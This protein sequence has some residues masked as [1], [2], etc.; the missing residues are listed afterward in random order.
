PLEPSAARAHLATSIYLQ[1]A[2]HPHIVHVVG[3]NEADHAATADDVIESCAIARRA[4]ENA[5]RGAPDM[6]SDPAVQARV[7]E[8][9]AEARV[10][11]DAICAVGQGKAG[12]LTDPGTLARAVRVGILDAPH[13]KNNAYAPGSI[14]TRIE[15]GGACVAVDPDTGRVLPEKERVA[16]ILNAL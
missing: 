13:L 3:Y 8:L 9:A 2:L 11:L 16:K 7:E 12:A 15:A 5:L 4:V 1:M 6:A 14:V 10:T